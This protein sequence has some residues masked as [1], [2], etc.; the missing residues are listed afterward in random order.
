M[1]IPL[2]ST[3]FQVFTSLSDAGYTASEWSGYRSFVGGQILAYR[4]ASVVAKVE[5]P[6]TETFLEWDN[7]CLA[8]AGGRSLDYGR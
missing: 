3:P 4:T 2:G 6:V 1:T 8:G 5:L 7:A